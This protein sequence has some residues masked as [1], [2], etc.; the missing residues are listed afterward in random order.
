MFGS[1]EVQE[2][3]VVVMGGAVVDGSSRRAVMGLH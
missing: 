3:A 2:E 1:K